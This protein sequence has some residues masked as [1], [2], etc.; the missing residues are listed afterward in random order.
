L[1]ATFLDLPG[2]RAEMDGVPIP[3]TNG[4][5]QLIRVT[6]PGEG[7]LKL[8]FEPYSDRYLMASFLLACLAATL[9]PFL[10]AGSK[11]RSGE[12]R[13][14]A[15]GPAPLD[16]GSRGPAGTAQ[17]ELLD[18]HREEVEANP[19]DRSGNAIRIPPHRGNR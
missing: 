4:E 5:D 10:L 1:V 17:L 6:A 18:G 15:D 2:W 14:N 11:P 16:E 13:S 19:M 12:V 9:V 3:I 7:V 8:S